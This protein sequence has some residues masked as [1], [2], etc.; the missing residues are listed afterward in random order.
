MSCSTNNRGLIA[1]YLSVFNY[2]RPTELDC[3]KLNVT[4]FR[5]GIT[6]EVKKGLG[7]LCPIFSTWFTHENVFSLLVSLTFTTGL[8]L[9]FSQ[10][11]SFS[12]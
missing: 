3:S 1:G 8:I 6:F 4:S 7:L 10:C 2:F 9:F 11:N 5:V 12:I